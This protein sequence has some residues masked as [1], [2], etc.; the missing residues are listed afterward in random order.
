MR[1]V[2]EVLSPSF[3]RREKGGAEKGMTKWNVGRNLEQL[4]TQ[5]T[6]FLLPLQ[7]VICIEWRERTGKMLLM[8]VG[9]KWSALAW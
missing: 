7:A 3:R 8:K 1:E 4:F 5:S 9:K 6:H 2:S